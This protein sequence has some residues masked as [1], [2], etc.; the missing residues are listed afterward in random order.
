MTGED[1]IARIRDERVSRETRIKQKAA[2]VYATFTSTE[3]F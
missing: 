2:A 3:P 1:I